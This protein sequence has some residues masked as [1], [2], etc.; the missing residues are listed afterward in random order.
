VKEVGNTNGEWQI[1]IKIIT[2]II[3]FGI[4]V[5]VSIAVVTAVIMLT[6]VLYI[7]ILERKREIGLLRSLGATKSDI[8]RIFVSE[9]AIIGLLAG[10]LSIGF[11]LLLV[12]IGEPIIYEHFGDIIRDAFPYNDGSFLYLKVSSAINAVI[13]SIVIAI[14][15]GLI[16]A[17][18]AAKKPPIDALRR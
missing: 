10:L 7:S 11:T 14:L 4:S 1:I 16:P 17:S 12:A 2:H 13:G 18:K 3:Q 15:G 5:I 6:M 9:T 8:K